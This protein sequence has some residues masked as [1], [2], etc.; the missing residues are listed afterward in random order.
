MHY[1]FYSVKI[2]CLYECIYYFANCL[3]HYRDST[4]SFCSRT[5]SFYYTNL[6]HWNYYMYWAINNRKEDIHKINQKHNK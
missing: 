4:E 3:K 5:I 2:T 6:Q 1:L